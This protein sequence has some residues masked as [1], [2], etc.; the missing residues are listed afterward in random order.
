MSIEIE[1]RRSREERAGDVATAVIHLVQDFAAKNAPAGWNGE[2]I[3]VG[4]AA[5]LTKLCNDCGCK[6]ADI[7]D[8]I[9]SVESA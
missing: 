6:P 2:E 5:A 4:V 7:L 1:D 9:E 8:G 3:L